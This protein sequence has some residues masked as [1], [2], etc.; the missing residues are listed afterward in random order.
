MR[1]PS[2]RVSGWWEGNRDTLEKMAP[3]SRYG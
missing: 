3:L 1:M 2:Q